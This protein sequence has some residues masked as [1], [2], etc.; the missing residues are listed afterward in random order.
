MIHVF[1]FFSLNSVPS[2]SSVLRDPYAV[3]HSIR[4]RVP[5]RLN[6]SP[7]SRTA[8]YPIQEPWWRLRTPRVLRV[9]V[10]LYPCPRTEGYFFF[11][12]LE[13][14]LEHR[15]LGIEH[16]KSTGETLVIASILYSSLWN[17]WL[18]DECTN[19]NWH[20]YFFFPAIMRCKSISQTAA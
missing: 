4:F 8:A 9:R 12:F 11:L 7:G 10:C 18:T 3:N 6:N 14:G 2:V 20:R 16:C 19:D 5:V 15:E 17:N 13:S 1:L